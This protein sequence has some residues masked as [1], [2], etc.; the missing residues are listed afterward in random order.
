MRLQDIIL[1]THRANITKTTNAG[2]KIAFDQCFHKGKTTTGLLKK[3]ICFPS[4]EDVLRMSKVVLDKVTNVFSMIVC[5]VPSEK[6]RNGK[7]SMTM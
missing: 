4:L 2:Y 7:L 6:R 5:F 3:T 1:E